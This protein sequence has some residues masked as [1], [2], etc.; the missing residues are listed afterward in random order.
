MDTNHFPVINVKLTPEMFALLKAEC[1]R[2]SVA[3]AS[4]VA[5]STVVVDALKAYLGSNPKLKRLARTRGKP[6][7]AP[8]A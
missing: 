4:H 5:Y 1:A 8:A 7:N 2:R 6:A 3:Q